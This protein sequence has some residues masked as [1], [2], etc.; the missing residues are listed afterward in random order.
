[1]K[2]S[3][4]KSTLNLKRCFLKVS[5]NFKKLNFR[6][7]RILQVITEHGVLLPFTGAGLHNTQKTYSPGNFQNPV[8]QPKYTDLEYI[9]LEQSG[10]TEH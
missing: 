9:V 2:S 5:Q 1:M 8:A 7:H 3:K 4:Q 6:F 10:C